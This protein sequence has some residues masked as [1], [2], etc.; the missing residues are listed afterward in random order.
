MSGSTPCIEGCACGRHSPY[1]RSA[2]TR[3]KLSASKAGVSTHASD[4]AC[5]WCRQKGHGRYNGPCVDCGH[6]VG[7]RSQRKRCLNCYNRLR[8]QENP[9]RQRRA[10][11]KH[12][13][14]ITAD[15]YCELLDRQNGACAICGHLA[16]STFEL[17]VDHD[18]SCCP[19]KKK[20]CGKCVR[21]L[22]CDRCNRGIG[23]FR[24]DPQVMQRAVWYLGGDD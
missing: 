5:G 22:L 19:A 16:A 1:E 14:G 12:L 18:H 9:E 15:E 2:E 6:P 24:D 17:A 4:C 11:I 8:Y 13:Y 21:G 20:A 10:Q 23:Y 7:D 3:A